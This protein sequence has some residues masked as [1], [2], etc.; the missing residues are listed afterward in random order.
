M[1]LSVR[2]SFQDDAGVFSEGRFI[3]TL[4]S[5]GLSEENYLKRVDNV[6]MRDQ[7]VGA[8]SSGVRFDST[9]AQAIAAF[10]LEKRVVRLT[11]F[12]VN[13]DM[14]AVPTDSE[15]DNFFAENKS[16]YECASVAMLRLP[17]YQLK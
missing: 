3:Q 17:V 16:S 1:P 2:K 14:I 11:S 6:L 12:P 7:L 4:S 9:T 10:D 8:L 15:I 5:A 13:P